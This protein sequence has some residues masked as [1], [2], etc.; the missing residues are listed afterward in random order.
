MF[1][2]EIIK[3][4]AETLQMA[5]DK[6]FQLATAESCTGGLIMGALTEVSG[7]SDVVDRG[8][9]TYTNRAKI[10]ML[11]VDGGI[12]RKHGAVSKECARAM[13]EG[14]LKASTATLAVSVTGV[15]GPDG[16]STGKPVGLV[17]IS[18]AR[19]DGTHVHEKNLFGDI[20][21]DKVRA[22]TVMAALGL[23]MTVMC[24]NTVSCDKK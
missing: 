13:A 8:F 17:H 11:N 14:A 9:V 6:G 21:R 12:I 19:R 20:G 15:A 5:R 4:A 22:A 2:D 24:D 3:R 7:S 10:D 16:A 18:C 23:F 1:S